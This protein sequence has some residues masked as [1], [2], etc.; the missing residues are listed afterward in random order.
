MCIYN[1]FTLKGDAKYFK[2]M[3]SYLKRT[4]CD[5]MHQNTL[6]YESSKIVNLQSMCNVTYFF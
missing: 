1:V 6:F 4:F 2:W 5:K 3:I